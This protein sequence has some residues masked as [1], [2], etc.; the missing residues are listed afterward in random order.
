MEACGMLLYDARFFNESEYILKLLFDE[1]TTET[2]AHYT[3]IFR[4]IPLEIVNPVVLLPYLPV[5][6]STM[7][8]A[9]MQKAR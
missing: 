8:S 2:V 6:K 1:L 7:M 5:G 3:S 9:F 4:L